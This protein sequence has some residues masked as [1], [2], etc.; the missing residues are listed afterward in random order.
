MVTVPDPLQIISIDED[1][2][3][4]TT[5][6]TMTTTGVLDT[7]MMEDKESLRTKQL[8]IMQESID[9]LLQEHGSEQD[10]QEKITKLTSE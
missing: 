7:A 1:E 3:T 10:L 9:K 6:V 5:D 8:C 2:P 4:L